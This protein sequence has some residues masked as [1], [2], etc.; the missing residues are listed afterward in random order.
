M[1]ET[2][3]TPTFHTGFKAVAIVFLPHST[4][5]YGGKTMT[6]F[7]GHRTIQHIRILSSACLHC[8]PVFR[9]CGF[10]LCIPA[11]R[12]CWAALRTPLL[13]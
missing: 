7:T 5:L 11:A 4:G 9:A 8:K 6:P 1:L 2:E 12:L 3:T 13:Y 10:A